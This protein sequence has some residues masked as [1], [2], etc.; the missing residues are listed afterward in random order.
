MLNIETVKAKESGELMREEK[1]WDLN[2]DFWDL[3]DLPSGWVSTVD[4][5]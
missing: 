4:I 3:N 1:L 2:F 5:L